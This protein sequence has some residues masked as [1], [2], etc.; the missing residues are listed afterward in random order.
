MDVLS[1]GPVSE[2]HPD[3]TSL[4]LRRY[5]AVFVMLTLSLLAATA[6]AYALSSL[7]LEYS[8]QKTS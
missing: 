8:Q 5:N 7:P 6:L 1:V 3:L 4:F 2:V